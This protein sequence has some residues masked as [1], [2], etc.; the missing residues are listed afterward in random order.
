MP[1]ESQ[2][3]HPRPVPP[4]TSSHLLEYQEPM[5]PLP[6]GASGSAAAHPSVSVKEEDLAAM[7]A[8]SKQTEGPRGPS[9]GEQGSGNKQANPNPDTSSSGRGMEQQGPPPLQA[10]KPHSE[11][12]APPA[13]RAS[14]GSEA[15]ELLRLAGGKLPAPPP[16][17][18]VPPPVAPTAPIEPP[19]FVG[20]PPGQERQSSSCDGGE[21]PPKGSPPPAASVA[22][23]PAP[24]PTLQIQPAPPPAPP[25]A[26][27]TSTAPVSA[28]LRGASVP[29]QPPLPLQQQQQQQRQVPPGRGAASTDRKSV[30]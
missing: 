16:A 20:L 12:A 7:A 9:D 22:D 10:L 5:D 8:S 1:Q 15:E 26:T 23:R 14:Q 19:S 13:P 2:R 17:G 27:L 21:A 28:A 4:H 24:L 25:P 29:S 3:T 30:V 11:S 18:V 6:G